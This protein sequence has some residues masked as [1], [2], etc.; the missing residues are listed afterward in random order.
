MRKLIVAMLIIVLFG[1]HAAAAQSGCGNGLP[2]GTVPWRLPTVPRLNSPTPMPTHVVQDDSINPGAPTATPAPFATPTDVGDLGITGLEDQIAT[3]QAVIDGTPITVEDH[4][5]TTE[6]PDM[7]ES[8]GAVFGFVLGLQGVHFGV[9]TPLVTFALF[10]MFTVIA[11]KAGFFIL[12]VIAVVFGFI[13]KI[14]SAI[15]EFI[16]L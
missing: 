15:L 13:R 10:G 4:G 14:I 5:L 16:P 12:P 11:L 1:G 3:L 9:L 6:E 2:C 8:A 7:G